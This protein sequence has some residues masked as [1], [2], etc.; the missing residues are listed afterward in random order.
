MSINYSGGSLDLSTS[1]KGSLGKKLRVLPD[2]GAVVAHRI[3]GGTL[4]PTCKSPLVVC[5]NHTSQ[6]RGGA[7]SLKTAGR[8]HLLSTCSCGLIG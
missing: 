6:N 8:V 5:S 3:V 7:T 1:L 4:A 2:F